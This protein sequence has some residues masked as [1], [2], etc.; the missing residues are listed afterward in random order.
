MRNLST[1][2]TGFLLVISLT[3][4]TILG[5]G[6][7]G[8]G[9]QAPPQL[10]YV[11]NVDPAELTPANA[12]RLL[13]HVVSGNTLTG[14]VPTGVV[15]N[16][17]AVYLPAP[18]QL[19]R[20]LRGITNF[21]LATN[22]EVRHLPVAIAINEQE[23][24]YPTGSIE[25]S[26]SVTYSGTLNDTTGTGTVTTTYYDCLNGD[27]FMDGTVVWQINEAIL[28][29]DDWY[30]TDSVFTFQVIT[31]SSPL[32]NIQL[33]GTLREVVATDVTQTF[34]V[35]LK[36]RNTDH[37]QKTE[38]LVIVTT[39]EIYPNYASETMAG[40]LYDSIDGYVDMTTPQSLVYATF[41]A[42]YPA[43]GQILLTCAG[44]ARLLATIV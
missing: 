10:I 4:L 9:G 24:C 39:L 37:M 23:L 41:D 5:S 32:F 40:R 36:D 11:G 18:S 13:A 31:M 25:P 12:T 30:P 42:V 29:P 38:N 26:G 27:L 44:N 8:D 35:V 19:A 1:R 33:G 17:P 21:P 16:S 22:S 3:V 20:Q 14:E 15:S 28:T 2:F 34:N 6:G 43:S 7:G